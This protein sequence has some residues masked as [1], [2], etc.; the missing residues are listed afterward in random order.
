[1]DRVG[2]RARK[3]GVFTS[4]TRSQHVW[5]LLHGIVPE[6]CTMT[7]LTGVLS[8][9]GGD[10]TARAPQR[11]L[12]TSSMPSGSGTGDSAVRGVALAVPSEAALKTPARP[13]ARPTHATTS[14]THGTSTSS[15]VRDL[16]ATATARGAPSGNCRKHNSSERRRQS[17]SPF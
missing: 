3:D 14:S 8:V 10:L 9:S 2:G 16:R 11:D 12:R 13:P 5:R 4:L 6:W 15:S 7:V 17:S 1:M